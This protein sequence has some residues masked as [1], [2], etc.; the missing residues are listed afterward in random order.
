MLEPWHSFESVA[1]AIARAVEPQACG[2]LA[3]EICQLYRDLLMPRL[4]RQ[5]WQHV[6]AAVYSKAPGCHLHN[7]TFSHVPQVFHAS[8]LEV[9]IPSEGEVA[10]VLE[11][12]GHDNAC[13]PKA[14]IHCFERQYTDAFRSSA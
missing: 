14:R 9:F 11:R 4:P 5:G 13:A 6:C 2:I 1:A 3:V 8:I 10:E 12:Q 7:P